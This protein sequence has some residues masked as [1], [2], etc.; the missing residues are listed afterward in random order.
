MHP[1]STAEVFQH[2]C[3]ACINPVLPLYHHVRGRLR[4]KAIRAFNRI[5]D[6]VDED[7]DGALSDK[8]L[9]RFHIFAFGRPPRVDELNGLK[10]VLLRCV[11]I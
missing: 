3:D 5:F 10:Q 7:K 6:I 11:Y 2:A 4:S 8:E 1:D 9:G